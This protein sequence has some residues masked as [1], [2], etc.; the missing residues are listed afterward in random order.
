MRVLLVENHSVLNNR[1]VE[2]LAHAG[3]EVDRIG[4]GEDALF[5]MRNGQFDVMLTETMLE[6]M[7]CYELVRTVRAQDT[8]LPILVIADYGRPQTRV[9]AFAV[10]ATE[11]I[12]RQT[13]Q[14][15]VIERIRQVTGNQS[16]PG[17]R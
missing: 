9:K 3:D 10:G 17:P 16:R 7:E 13:P 5:A 8:M 15:E 11:V 2:L 12:D 6:D 14:L 4:N 1:L